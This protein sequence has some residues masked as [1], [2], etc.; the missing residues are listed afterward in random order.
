MHPRFTSVFACKPLAA[1]MAAGLMLASV[2]VLA[3]ESPDMA[4][5]AERVDQQ[6]TQLLGQYPVPGASIAI[7][8]QGKLVYQRGYGMAVTE[9]NTPVTP[10]TRFRIGSVSKPVTAVAVLKLFEKELPQ[11]LDRPVLH[12]HGGAQG[13]ERRRG[14]P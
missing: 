3:Q 2:S 4:A 1:L 5:L 14:Q 8:Y 10:L 11:V 13:P 9:S 12:L 7:A 6:M